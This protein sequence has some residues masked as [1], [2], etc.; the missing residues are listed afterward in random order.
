[1]TNGQYRFLVAEQLASIVN[2]RFSS[3]VCWEAT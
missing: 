3:K 1:V 2:L